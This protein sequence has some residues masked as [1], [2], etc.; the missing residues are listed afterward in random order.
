LPADFSSGSS[1]NRWADSIRFQAC[2]FS[3]LQACNF[4]CLQACKFRILRA[5]GVHRRRQ[6]RMGSVLNRFLFTVS[7]KWLLLTH[8]DFALL[9][10]QTNLVMV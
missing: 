2:K 4:R 5:C 3:N 1:N 9:L 10:I 8:A 6:L 7:K